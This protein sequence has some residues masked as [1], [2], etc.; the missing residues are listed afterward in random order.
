MDKIIDLHIHTR[1]SDGSDT[2][3]EILKKCKDLNLEYISITDHDTCE[4]Y[5]DIKKMCKGVFCYN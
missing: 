2:T 5:N 3:E 4:A 1:N